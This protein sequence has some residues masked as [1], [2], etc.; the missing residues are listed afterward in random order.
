METNEHDVYG[1]YDGDFTFHVVEHD[2]EPQLN[3]SFR[4]R[5]DSDPEE[6]ARANERNLNNAPNGWTRV[7]PATPEEI[8]SWLWRFRQAFPTRAKR[9]TDALRLLRLA[10]AQAGLREEQASGVMRVALVE[11]T[12]PTAR[13]RDFAEKPVLFVELRDGAFH[14]TEEGRWLTSLMK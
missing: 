1:F 3:A 12:L 8:A 13:V 10:D 7:R 4:V 6:R 2:D 11:L 5:I 9:H 14:L